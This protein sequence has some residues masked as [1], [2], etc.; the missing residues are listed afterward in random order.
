MTNKKFVTNCDGIS[1]ELGNLVFSEN[2]PG[3]TRDFPL[4]ELTIYFEIDE[5]F[6]E[7]KVDECNEMICMNFFVSKI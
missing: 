3:E 6:G 2:T 1:E 7:R 5:E 4:H